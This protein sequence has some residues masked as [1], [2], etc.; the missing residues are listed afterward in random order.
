MDHLANLGLV[1]P[2]DFIVHSNP[3]LELIPLVKANCL[4][5]CCNNLYPV[6]SY[7]S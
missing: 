3:P 2:L 4:G 6:L 1:Q 7:F 5:S